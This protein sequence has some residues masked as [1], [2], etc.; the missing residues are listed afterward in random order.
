MIREREK[1]LPLDVAGERLLELSQKGRCALFR[2]ESPIDRRPHPVHVEQHVDRDHHHQNDAEEDLD[3]A[4]RCSF[5]QR[6]GLRRGSLDV[7]AADELEPV[8]ADLDSLEMVRV[9]PDLQAVDVVF[10]PRLFMRARDGEVVV[11]AVGVG[12]HLIRADGRKRDDAEG[13]GGGEGEVDDCDGDS[14]R[15]PDSAQRAH[16]WVQEQGDQP[17]HDEEEDGASDRA[18]KRPGEQEQERQADELNPARNRDPGRPVRH[19]RD[20]TA[21][22]DGT[23]GARD[24]K[25]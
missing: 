21:P 22:T 3:C 9:E 19:S 17:G 12:A 24:L 18:R 20:R 2:R 10:R 6:D 7:D 25:A 8:L 14:T 15:N 1:K 13:R 4:Q 23:D 16:Y 11:D 5:D